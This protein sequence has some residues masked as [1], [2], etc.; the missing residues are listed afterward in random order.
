MFLGDY[1]L[2]KKGIGIY[3]QYENSQ[4]YPERVSSQLSRF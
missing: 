1:M 4:T 2:M 3:L